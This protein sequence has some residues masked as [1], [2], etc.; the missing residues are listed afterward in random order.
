MLLITMGR[1]GGFSSLENSI[2]ENHQVLKPTPPPGPPQ[3]SFHPHQTYIN[4]LKSTPSSTLIKTLSTPSR[5]L[6]SQPSFT[7]LQ[8]PQLH[9]LLNPLLHLINPISTP[10]S[11]L[12]LNPPLCDKLRSPCSV[13]SFR[14]FRLKILQCM[15]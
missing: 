9:S 5:T 4:A 11:L 12:L 14:H 6:P 1:T 10:S 13:A 2:E 7:P 8:H 15:Y 3:P